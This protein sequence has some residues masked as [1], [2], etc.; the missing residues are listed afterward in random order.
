MQGIAAC[1]VICRFEA[2]EVGATDDDDTVL[3]K[4]LMVE[5]CQ[6]DI[7]NSG[8][9]S[10]HCMICDHLASDKGKLRLSAASKQHSKLAG[11]Q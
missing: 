8:C 10:V 2:A 4:I 1:V 7:S 11:W 3:Y 5:P 6:L 9:S